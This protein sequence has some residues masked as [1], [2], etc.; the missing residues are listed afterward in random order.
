MSES[1]LTDCREREKAV[2]ERAAMGIREHAELGV[3]GWILALL[4][5]VLVCRHTATYAHTNTV[6][7]PIP[8]FVHN[9]RQGPYINEAC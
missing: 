8:H 4:R 7:H 2:A 9:N 1:E 6:I 3:T 5:E